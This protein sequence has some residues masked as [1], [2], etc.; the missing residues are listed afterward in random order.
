MNF[1]VSY[2]VNGN[3]VTFDANGLPIIETEEDG[4]GSGGGDAGDPPGT[5]TL[6]IKEVDSATLE[7][8][9]A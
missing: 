4:L 2:K 8:A 7:S 3:P 9:R 5:I 1:N 6:T